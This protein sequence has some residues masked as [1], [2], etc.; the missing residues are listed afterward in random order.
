MDQFEHCLLDFVN[1]AVVDLTTTPIIE[2]A[3]CREST[4]GDVCDGNDCKNK[5]GDDVKASSQDTLR[6]PEEFFELEPLLFP[7]PLMTNKCEFSTPPQGADAID[8]DSDSLFIVDEVSMVVTRKRLQDF[9]IDS[10]SSELKNSHRV[11]EGE[12]QIRGFPHHHGLI[13]V[14][15]P[16][17]LVSTLT[18]I[19][20]LFSILMAAFPL[21]SLHLC[22]SFIVDISQRH[23]R[24]RNLLRFEVRVACFTGRLLI[25]VV[26][27]LRS[28]TYMF[29]YYY[30]SVE[31]IMD[32]ILSFI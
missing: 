14:E 23:R 30:V 6:L 9:D 3:D 28:I 5:N 18:I 29:Y 31:G 2:C 25:I 7:P 17:N 1:N 21:F 12:L 22:Q 10:Q 11:M 32:C 15:H 24:K 19:S 13:F 16:T 27:R 8:H 4:V 26:D 20:Q